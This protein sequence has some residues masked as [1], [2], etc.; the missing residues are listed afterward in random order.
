MSLLKKR[1]KKNIINKEINKTIDSL[2]TK[3]QEQ[4]RSNQVVKFMTLNQY[5]DA[6]KKDFPEFIKND[7]NN[8]IQSLS[9]TPQEMNKKMNDF[10]LI[11]DMLKSV[12]EEIGRSSLY[13]KKKKEYGALVS[14]NQKKILKLTN[15]IL[16]YRRLAS[17][18]QEFINKQVVDLAMKNI[19]EKHLTF[20]TKDTSTLETNLKVILNEIHIVL[21]DQ[22]YKEERTIIKYQRDENN[23]RVRYIRYP[24]PKQLWDATT[25]EI[26]LENAESQIHN[27]SQYMELLAALKSKIQRL[28][29]RQRLGQITRGQ[30]GEKLTNSKEEF[31]QILGNLTKVVDE[32]TEKFIKVLMNPYFELVKSKPNSTTNYFMNPYIKRDGDMIFV[33]D[34]IQ[35]FSALFRDTKQSRPEG[36]LHMFQAMVKMM[37]DNLNLFDGQGGRLERVK[38]INWISQIEETYKKDMFKLKKEIAVDHVIHKI[39]LEQRKEKGREISLEDILKSMPAPKKVDQ[40]KEVRKLIKGIK[41]DAWSSIRKQILT[42]T[43]NARKNEIPLRWYKEM[44]KPSSLDYLIVHFTGFF[45]QYQNIYGTYPYDLSQDSLEKFRTWTKKRIDKGRF[46]SAW[47]QHYIDLNKRKFLLFNKDT[48]MLDVDMNRA[49][50]T[51]Q[52]L[53]DNVRKAYDE[54][55]KLL[56]IA[57]GNTEINMTIVKCR[58]EEIDDEIRELIRMEGNEE[59]I[60]KLEAEKSSCQIQAD[61]A[62]VCNLCGV[63]LDVIL[64]TAPETYDEMV[65]RRLNQQAE[66]MEIGYQEL[67]RQELEKRM[68]SLIDQYMQVMVD[69]TNVRVTTTVSNLRNTSDISRQEVDKIKRELGMIIM[70]NEQ[71]IFNSVR[72]VYKPNMVTEVGNQAIKTQIMGDIAK[73]LMIMY[74]TRKFPNVLELPTAKNIQQM[75][76]E[77]P[78]LQTSV[79][80]DAYKFEFRL[81]YIIKIYNQA[82]GIYNNSE[83][84]QFEEDETEIVESNLDQLPKDDLEI[85]TASFGITRASERQMIREIKQ[86]KQEEKEQQVKETDELVKKMVAHALDLYDQ[87]LQDTFSRASALYEGDVDT[88]LFASIVAQHL[89]RRTNQQLNFKEYKDLFLNLFYWSRVENENNPSFQSYK[90]NVERINHPEISNI[91]LLKEQRIMFV[92]RFKKVKQLWNKLDGLL[93]LL[94]IDLTDK[95]LRYMVMNQKAFIKGKNSQVEVSPKFSL[96]MGYLFHDG[97]RISLV[98]LNELLNNDSFK[99]KIQSLKQ[100]KDDLKAKL[101]LVKKDMK[102]LKQIELLHKQY[103]KTV[104]LSPVSSYKSHMLIDVLLHVR[105][106]YN[107][108]VSDRLEVIEPLPGNQCPYCPYSGKK[109]YDHL[110]DVHL[111]LENSKE[112]YKI[113]M[114]NRYQSHLRNLWRQHGKGKPSERKMKNLDNKINMLEI[115]QTYC[116]E[117]TEN[118]LKRHRFIGEKC[119][120]CS[121]TYTQITKDGMGKKAEA[122]AK[123]MKNYVEMLDKR[124]CLSKKFDQIHENEECKRMKDISLL[125]PIQEQWHLLRKNAYIQKV[126]IDSIVRKVELYKRSLLAQYKQVKPNG[127]L[128]HENLDVVDQLHGIELRGNEYVL[129][130][131]GLDAFSHKYRILSDKTIKQIFRTK[132]ILKWDK[133][134]KAI[135]NPDGNKTIKE[136]KKEIMDRIVK[137]ARKWLEDNQGD[138]KQFENN[139]GAKLPIMKLEKYDIT[140][141]PELKGD[142][143]KRLIQVVQQT[144]ITLSKLNMGLVNPYVHNSYLL[145]QKK[146]GSQS[147]GKF[148]GANFKGVLMQAPLDLYIGG[149]FDGSQFKGVLVQA[150]LDLYKM[151]GGDPFKGILVER[152]DALIERVQ[153]QQGGAIV[154]QEPEYVY[155]KGGALPFMAAKVG[156]KKFKQ[157]ANNPA[158]RQQALGIGQNYLQN[159]GQQF[160]Q[161][162]PN[163]AQQGQQFLQQ[164][165]NFVN[166]VRQQGQQKR[167]Q[168]GFGTNEGEGD[169]YHGLPVTNIQVYEQGPEISKVDGLVGGR[170]NDVY[171]GLIVVPQNVYRGGFDDPR[172]NDVYR[173]LVTSGTSEVYDKQNGGAIIVQEGKTILGGKSLEQELPNDVNT[174]ADIT[175]NRFVDKPV[176]EDP[177]QIQE[178]GNR[179][180]QEESDEEDIDELRNFLSNGRPELLADDF[181]NTHSP[182]YSTSQEDFIPLTM[183]DDESDIEDTEIVLD[184]MRNQFRRR[185]R[186]PMQAFSDMIRE[187]IQTSIREGNV[188]F[189]RE[190]L[191][192]EEERENLDEYLGLALEAN[193][194]E[195]ARV[196]IEGGADIYARSGD[197]QNT[198]LHNAVLNGDEAMVEMLINHGANPQMTNRDDQRPIDLTSNDDIK[199]ILQGF[200]LPDREELKQNPTKKCKEDI[201]IITQMEWKD[202]DLDHLIYIKWPTRTDCYLADDL[203]GYLKTNKPMVVWRKNTEGRPT[204]DNVGYGYEPN[205]EDNRKFIPLYPVRNWVTVKSVKKVL[206]SKKRNFEAKKIGKERLGNQEGSFGVSEKHA[207]QEDQL[208]ELVE[209]KDPP[210][211]KKHNFLDKLI[212]KKE[213]EMKEQKGGSCDV[214][215][216]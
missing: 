91:S 42:I 196:L 3:E 17:L 61:D 206:R 34:V 16:E 211:T 49:R 205:P 9:G 53:G 170:G 70:S 8:R 118:N 92:D 141:V 115:Y 47:I 101:Q 156:M 107:F 210:M 136:G 207:Q 148:N 50:F 147:G 163:F 214:C 2:T 39:V 90:T 138:V 188:E 26:N 186:D 153:N 140:K 11:L 44:A 31:K 158:V 98:L 15:E 4:R 166:Q 81:N 111:K 20:L 198:P 180:S 95:N 216:I 150:P 212:E 160:L 194:V 167:T 77:L 195:V 165:P 74:F 33:Y 181:S 104:F 78:S 76:N 179:N 54:A 137:N 168:Y 43:W 191:E 202:E 119:Q 38:M 209:S 116:D 84:D 93:D 24:H 96:L 112:M 182:R 18:E 71:N 5:I 145:S 114:E 193:Q 175:E 72:S 172:I 28:P 52:T 1:L 146:N 103:N 159:Q 185:S 10:V 151:K 12:K 162:N 200:E 27:I 134:I 139:V 87:K 113:G 25:I 64:D 88:T 75:F 100:H 161:Q 149:K 183:A 144:I 40:A 110:K 32:A 58:H 109:I 67:Q 213:K 105:T 190:L 63:K 187:R 133:T 197:H 13:P 30:R 178:G 128:L 82:V 7:I 6:F 85:V 21:V 68:I 62:I 171:R 174:L 14:D 108:H 131:D 36:I 152:Q 201:N 121:R 169:V 57:K 73:M 199:E 192:D 45:Y 69:K 56:E 130:Y 106:S 65:R 60:K 29:N 120:Y 46:M 129:P 37:A 94:K 48:G 157:Y 59:Q 125:I 177:N 80:Q 154:V 215:T 86:K 142:R 127:D 22:L 184:R 19:Q 122:L 51:I 99:S 176:P 155:H 79:S 83:Q 164:N 123:D 89:G 208:W 117:N 132:D 203:V 204:D 41:K 126:V 97:S 124:Y 135:D 102:E 35:E 143:T 173:G 189:V 55:T 23:Q 66:D